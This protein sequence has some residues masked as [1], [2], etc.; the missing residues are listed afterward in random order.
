MKH[1]HHRGTKTCVQAKK[2]Y[3]SSVCSRWVTAYFTSAS[4]ANRLPARCLLSGPKKITGL[5]NVHSNCNVSRRYGWDGTNHSPT[6]PISHQVISAI[7]IR[8]RH[9]ASRHFL[10]TDTWHQFLL[11]QD[12]HHGATVGQMLKCQW[13]MGGGLM[14][15][16][17]LSVRHIPFDVR[18]KFMTSECLVL[19]FVKLLCIYTHVSLTNPVKPHVYL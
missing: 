10:A 18:I 14:C 17:L 5:H 15:Y 13:W 1:F 12:K 11:R 6:V 7:C 16:H 3:V 19:H 4:A 2:K 8:H 9:E